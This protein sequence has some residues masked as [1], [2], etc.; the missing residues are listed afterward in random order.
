M[1]L[2]AMPE[3]AVT[4]SVAAGD[5]DSMPRAT[6]EA[7]TFSKAGRFLFRAGAVY[8]A[9]EDFWISPGFT[10][11]GGYH[12]DERWGVDLSSSLYLSTL[13]AAA[14][15]LRERDG[16]LP[17]AQQ[18]ILRVAAG[19]RYAFGYGKL[20]LEDLAIVLHFDLSLALRAG[21]LLTDQALN[22]GGELGLALQVSS[23]S[24]LVWVELGGWLGY[25][26][27][28]GG[29]LAGGPYGAGG[30]GLRL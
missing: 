29:A 1:S 23:G 7:R 27:R 4:S 25:E 8:W 3:L 6:V 15:E 14:R 16:V 18:P 19:P 12:F 11:E 5:K 30:V 13:D 10:L 24:F 17:D 21:V 9:R 26:E 28:S 20:L 2:G 22:P